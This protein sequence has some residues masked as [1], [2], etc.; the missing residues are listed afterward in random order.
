M[1]NFSYYSPTQILFGKDTHLQVGQLLKEKNVKKVLFHYGGGSIHK[2]GLYTQIITSL[3]Q[4]EVTFIE[5]GGVKPNPRLDMVRQGVEICKKENIDFILAVGGGSTIDSAKA[6]AVGAKYN[7]DVWDFYAKKAVATSALP[8]GTVLTIPAAGSETSP[9]SVITKEDTNEKLG[10]GTDLIRP[11]FAILNPELC[12]TLPAYQMACGVSD[13]LAHLMERYF[14]NTTDVD[15]T[16]RVLEASMRSIIQTAPRLLENPKDYQAWANIMWAGTMA[17]NGI[18]GM[19][20]E[21]DWGSHNIEH[22]LSAV[23]DIAHGAGLAVIF[24]AWIKYVYP[25]NKNR[26]VQFALR[27]FHC[28]AALENI[29][30]VIMQAVEKLQAFY[31][32]MGLPTSLKEM[33]IDQSHFAQMAKTAVQFGPTGKFQKL[34][35]EDVYKIYQLAL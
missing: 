6:I 2:T 33:N 28:D 5:L 29:D 16:D 25:T 35:E 30:G 21:E 32:R 13:M 8:V 27:V 31:H 26:F 19:G 17:H 20:R 11:V 34:G 14:T 24:P 18:L 23:Y 12:Y 3:Q 7:G 1:N 10:Y 22:Q 9:N 15:Y 4:A